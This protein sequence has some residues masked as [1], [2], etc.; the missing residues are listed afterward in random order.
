MISSLFYIDEV[1]M[2]GAVFS[3]LYGAGLFVI[4][5]VIAALVIIISQR[6]DN[7]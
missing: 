6:S 2:I 1:Y 7:R 3:F 4:L 5:V